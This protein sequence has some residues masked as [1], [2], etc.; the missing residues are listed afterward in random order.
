MSDIVEAIKDAVNPKR[1]E[2]ATVETYDPHKRGPYPDQ[3]PTGDGQPGLSPSTTTEAQN[4][5]TAERSDLSSTVA[6]GGQHS[7]SVTSQTLNSAQPSAA[8]SSA[9]RSRSRVAEALDPRAESTGNGSGS[10][11]L[12]DYGGAATKPVHKEGG[13]YGLS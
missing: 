9:G 13:K 10:Q 8:Q 2:Q 4:P 7:G 5:G 6:A 1:R 11:G 12:G 3:P